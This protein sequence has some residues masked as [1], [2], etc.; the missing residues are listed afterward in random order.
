MK[1][2]GRAKNSDR[3]NLSAGYRSTIFTPEQKDVW[4]TGVTGPPQNALEKGK[5]ILRNLGRRVEK[6]GYPKT[7]LVEE[8][9]PK[10]N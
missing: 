10:V 7:S 6:V 5:G 3:M 9:P 1:K 2:E 4:N 8:G